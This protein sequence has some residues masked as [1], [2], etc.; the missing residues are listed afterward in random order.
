MGSWRMSDGMTDIWDAYNKAMYTGGC[1]RSS[2]SVTHGRE[3]DCHTHACLG[4]ELCVL[5]VKLDHRTGSMVS[6][7]K[8]CGTTSS[9]WQLF[10]KSIRRRQ[11][12]TQVKQ[13]YNKQISD[14]DT[15][16]ANWVYS[17]GGD[18]FD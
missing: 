2:R 18:A 1:M 16:N 15:F 7:G 17:I 4:D 6:E 13:H 10:T 9:A 12:D 3:R 14:F 8:R 5:F 11:D